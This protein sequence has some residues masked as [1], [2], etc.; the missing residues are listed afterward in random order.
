MD[1]NKERVMELLDN[2]IMRAQS[3]KDDAKAREDW[4]DVYF[5][6]GEEKVAKEIKD[7]ISKWDRG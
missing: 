7:I 5:Y 4:S 3:W 2:F 6:Q 1:L